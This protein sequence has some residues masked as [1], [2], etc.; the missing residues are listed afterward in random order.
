MSA[1]WLGLDGALGAFSVALVADDDSVDARTAV[2][3]G[4]DALER[5]LSLLDEVAGGIGLQ[6]LHALAVG[7]GPGSF[8]GLRIALA[9]AKSLAFAARLPLA[10][11]SSYDAVVPRDIG[12]T[13]AAFVHG[14]AGIACARL[15]VATSAEGAPWRERIVCG[16]YAAIAGAF[17]HELSPGTLLPAYGASEGVAPALGERDITVQAIA[18]Q[19]LVPALAIVRRAIASKSEGDPHAL[20]ADYGEAHYAER[21]AAA[22]P[23]VPS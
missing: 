10:G 6:G 23:E 19:P 15:R 4:N 16:T 7:T 5:G 22:T 2:A 8:T 13:H 21:S 17:A 14:R 18:P 11:I 3:A 20:R 1:L 12:E 9:Y